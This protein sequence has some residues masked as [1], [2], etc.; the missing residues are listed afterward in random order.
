MK[1]TGTWVLTGVACC[2]VLVLGTWGLFGGGRSGGGASQPPPSAGLSPGQLAGQ[3]MVAGFEGRELPDGLRRAIRKGR[4]GGVILFADNLPDRES[5]RRLT[6]RI[7]AIPR[8]ARLR[9]YPL[10][11][12]ID[13]E[14]GLVKRL[15]GAPKA[16]AAEM[17]RRG[18]AFSRRQGILTGR[19]LR[20]VG[21][22]MN[23]APVLDV[24][25]PGGDIFAT[26]RAFGTTVKRVERTAIP[27][28]QGLESTGV[29]STAKHFPGL[30]RIEVNTDFAVQVVTS[31][32][33]ALR[34]VDEAPFR[35]YTRAGGD[36]VMVGTAVYPAFGRRPAAF[37]GRI[38]RG[39]LR[40]RV[41]FRGVTI[42]D[43]LGT[44][45]ARAFGGPR[46]TTVA[47]ARVGVD[48]LLFGD[49]VFPLRGQLALR[50]AFREGRIP[51]SRFRAAVDRI[52]ELR[53]RVGRSG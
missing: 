16:S 21:V 9:P 20:N 4:I 45:A 33:A 26:D 1:G 52:L 46:R 48:L 5:A 41:G 36:A 15:S 11:V 18:P 30:G 47:A 49:A 23:L 12:M 37:N 44:V 19:N 2:A 6:R 24:A 29:A 8:P 38:V 43:A 53:A 10:L 34:K 40:E 31:S 32:R 50:D 35:A 17:G 27:F 14:G 22:N 28:A 13:Q 3:R 51:A 7:Q 39:E 42:S 25:R